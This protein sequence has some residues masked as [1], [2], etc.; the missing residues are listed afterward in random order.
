MP[1]TQTLT[2]SNEQLATQMAKVLADYRRLKLYRTPVTDAF[3]KHAKP[4]DGSDS[5]LIPWEDTDHSSP[6]ALVSGYERWN[7]A[8]S[9]TMTAG[10]MTPAW[11]VQPIMIAEIDELINSGPRK[12]I[13]RLKKNTQNVQDHFSRN[14]Q[15]VVMRGPSSSGSYVAPPAFSSWNTFN[16]IDFSTGFFQNVAQGANTIHGVA[17]SGYAF[18]TFPRF[19]NLTFDVASAAGTNLATMMFQACVQMSVNDDWPSTSE[20]VWYVT[21]NVVTF[22]KKFM[23]TFEMYVDSGK[24]DD[25]KR[26]PIGP[27]GVPLMAI[28]DMPIDGA[29]SAAS[30]MSGL[31][32]NW[33]RGTY[34]FLF[35]GWKMDTTGFS[36]IPGTAGVR[37]ALM[38]LG[39]N[40]SCQEPGL[41]VTLKNA[42]TY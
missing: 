37:A 15:K 7:D 25:A 24:L 14:V 41:Q 11:V 12:V 6:T 13:D 28:A 1:G 2:L 10:R 23:R 5:I 18:A 17:Q 22:L 29:S 26:M 39:G 31:M 27:G 16:G 9:T 20:C 34:P 4:W 35:N 33:G 32:V 40:L 38:K 30:K 36:D 3:L 8:V 21:V 42:E 19:S